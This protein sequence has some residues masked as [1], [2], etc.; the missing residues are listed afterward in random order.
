MAALR[1]DTDEATAARVVLSVGGNETA[2]SCLPFDV[3]ILATMSRAFVGT[4]T[5]IQADTI[6]ARVDGWYLGGDTSTVELRTVDDAQ[7]LLGGFPL[8]VGNQ[9]LISALDD[10]IS[11]CG[12]SGPVTPELQESFA[13]A[14][15]GR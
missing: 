3:E 8:V 1:N 2:G 14:F 9:Y 15:S 12:Y 5:D 11:Y 4:V 7:A 6:T 13:A 10:A